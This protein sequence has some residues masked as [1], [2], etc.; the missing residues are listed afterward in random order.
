M[1]FLNSHRFAQRLTAN[2]QVQMAPVQFD[3]C[4]A[5]ASVCKNRTESIDQQTLRKK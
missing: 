2:G 5:F 1:D 3:Q 4:A